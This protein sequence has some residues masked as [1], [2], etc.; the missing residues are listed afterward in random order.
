MRDAAIVS[1]ARMPLFPPRFGAGSTEASRQ[2]VAGSL[3]GL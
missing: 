1:T 3:G 2:I